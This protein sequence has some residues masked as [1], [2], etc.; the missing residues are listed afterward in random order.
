[1]ELRFTPPRDGQM[2]FYC[3]N[4]QH[5]AVPQEHSST[6]PC[7]NCGQE[8]P[9]AIIIDPEIVWHFGEGIYSHET[10]GILVANEL[11]QL[12]FFRR[13]KFPF[14]LTIPAGHR[15]V[16]ESGVTTA[17]R[18]LLEETGYDV[19]TALLDFIGVD[20]LKGDGCR[21]GSD[22]HA[23]TTFITRQPQHQK[24]RITEDEGVEA[25]WLRAST[26][27]AVPELTYGT[28]QILLRN[29]DD[30]EEWLRK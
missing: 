23:W 16:G 30:I 21:R 5:P 12:L 7:S 1:M 11:G 2:H 4:C 29:Q 24:L 15:D 10:V 20:D 28:R 19:P 8:Q 14:G 25:I 13:V 22:R 18:E 9:R 3:I 26:A 27:L 17:R 6:Y